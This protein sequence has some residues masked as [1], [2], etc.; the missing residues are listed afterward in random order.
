ML[1]QAETDFSKARNAVIERCRGKWCLTIDADEYF[2]GN[3]E[4]LISLVKD[5]K[6]DKYDFSYGSSPLVHIYLY[7]NLLQ[8]FCQ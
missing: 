1:T 6:Y 8:F 3:V 7:I 4:E 2:A 5:S